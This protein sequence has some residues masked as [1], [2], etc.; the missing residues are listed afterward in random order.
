VLKSFQ[1]ETGIRPIYDVF[2][3]AETMESKLL[4]GNSGYD[5]VF[6]GTA[7]L[8]HLITAG[9]VQPLTARSCRTGSTWTPSS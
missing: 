7:N 2:D 8:G 5:V 1:E 6:P 4:T 3:S 9:A